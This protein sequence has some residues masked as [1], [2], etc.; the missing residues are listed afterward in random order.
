MR[1]DVTTE[2]DAIGSQSGTGTGFIVDPSGII[3]TNAHV[4]NA[5]TRQQAVQIV[6]TLSNG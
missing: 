1:I 3:V 4:A 5:E 6:V 2:P